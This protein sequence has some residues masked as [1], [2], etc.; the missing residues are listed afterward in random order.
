MSRTSAREYA[1]KVLY[2]RELNPESEPI[3]E[4]TLHLEEKDKAFADALIEAMKKTESEY[5]NAMT[6]PSWW[7]AFNVI[8]EQPTAY[9]IDKVVEELEIERKTANNTYNSFNMDVDLG[10]VFGLEK[11]IEIVKQGGVADDVCE[12]KMDNVGASIGC[13][14]VLHHTGYVNRTYCPYCGKKIKLVE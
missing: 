2:S 13:R 4:E 5:E 14:S 6:C 3:E 12:W 9:D 1:L 11:A 7:S 10:R 8:S